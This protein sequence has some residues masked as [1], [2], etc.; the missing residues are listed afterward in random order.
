M[1]RVLL[2]AGV[3]V[4][5]SN[6]SAWCQSA[7]V[8][9]TVPF[10]AR[11]LSGHVYVEST[12]LGL[13]GVLVEIC[14]SH[15]RNPIGSTKTDADGFFNLAG[16]RPAKIYHLRLSK[17]NFNTELVKVKVRSTV[18]HDLRLTIAPAT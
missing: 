15:W 9:R 7:V 16:Y 1:A 6:A 8:V 10:E 11:S 2:F 13:E 4:L 17:S 5:L 12:E 18:A 14:D 3:I